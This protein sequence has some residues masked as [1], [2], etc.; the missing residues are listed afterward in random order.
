MVFLEIVEIKNI[1]QRYYLTKYIS[2]CPLRELAVSE[3]FISSGPFSPIPFV[4]TFYKG[5][6]LFLKMSATASALLLE[7]FS[8]YVS[9]PSSLAWPIISRLYPRFINNFIL[10]KIN[11]FPVFPIYFSRPFLEINIP[12]NRLSKQFL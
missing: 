1:Y 2:T 12:G 5:T 4:K 11:Q 3:L 6:P 9:L 7:R 8:L 10:Q